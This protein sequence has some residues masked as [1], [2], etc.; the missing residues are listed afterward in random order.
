MI[1]LVA[2]RVVRKAGPR[3]AQRVVMSLVDQGRKVR[4]R[5]NKNAVQVSA[6]ALN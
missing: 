5:V 2:L 1:V 4:M 3:A 6:S